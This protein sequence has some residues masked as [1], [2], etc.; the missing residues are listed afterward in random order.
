M[1]NGKGLLNFKAASQISP[2]TQK[3]SVRE[4]YETAQQNQSSQSQFLLHLTS[5]LSDGIKSSMINVQY[6]QAKA[7]LVCCETF[8][9]QLSNRT[10]SRLKREEKR[11]S[12][13]NLKLQNN[14]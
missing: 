4:T 6:C 8:S 13:G 5:M 12:R 2:S 3:I 9:F 14:I 11:S 1:S 10:N 7:R